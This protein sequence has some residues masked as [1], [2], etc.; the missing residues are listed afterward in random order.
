MNFCMTV[1]YGY[2]HDSLGSTRA[3]GSYVIDVIIKI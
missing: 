2:F 3:T 1:L